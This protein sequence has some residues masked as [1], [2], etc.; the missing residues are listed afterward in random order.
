MTRMIPTQEI[1]RRARL[2]LKRAGVDAPPVPIEKIA[3]H[4]GIRIERSD[5]GEGCSGVLVREGDR[6]VI[7]VNW[8]HH[9][10]RQRFT[11]A[12]EIAHF[13]LHEGATYVDRG[14]RLNFRDLES[15]SGTKRE[16]I[17]ANAFAAALL[18][19]THWVR[20]DFIRRPFDLAA[21][22]EDLEAMA[23]RFQVS[24]QA[25][26]IRLANVVEATDEARS[27]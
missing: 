24:T 3:S 23:Q 17:Q 15:G 2:L 8:D 9:P 27:A 26:A 7:G 25:M 19:P 16:E 5:L 13:E 11:I 1:E 6:A 20:E 22:S 10:N 4:L 18:M 12:H 21:D 14:Y